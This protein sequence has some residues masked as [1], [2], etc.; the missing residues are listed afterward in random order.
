M[1]KVIKY[2]ELV[3]IWMKFAISWILVAMWKSRHSPVEKCDKENLIES[4][5]EFFNGQQ[6]FFSLS[7]RSQSSN[8]TLL[9]SS[10]H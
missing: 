4:L 5:N 9:R 6:F 1:N 3:D 8:E 10:K 7:H 2:K